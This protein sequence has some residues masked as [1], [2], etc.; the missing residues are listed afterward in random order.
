[1]NKPRYGVV[2]LAR[3]RA[4]QEITGSI[5]VT[6]T[7]KKNRYTALLLLLIFIFVVRTNFYLYEVSNYKYNEL[8]DWR[9]GAS[10]STLQSDLH[11]EF[12]RGD[13]SAVA[14]N[15]N[16]FTM[17]TNSQGN[18]P[19]ATV[20]ATVNVQQLV[21]KA[22]DLATTAGFFLEYFNQLPYYKSKVNAFNAVSVMHYN[23]FGCFKYSSYSQFKNSI[24]KNV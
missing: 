23:Y 22:N 11:C 3:L 4:L 18:N 6:A 2:R 24:F 8:T 14:Q 10:P 15:K 1:M 21:Q 17:R 19:Q 13:Q 9:R 20:M 12:V 5:P 16:I 7:M